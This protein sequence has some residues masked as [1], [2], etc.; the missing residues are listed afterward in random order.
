MQLFASFAD[1]IFF[2]CQSLNGNSSVRDYRTS[3]FRCR[4][5]QKGRALQAFVPVNYSAVKSRPPHEVFF[6]R[7]EASGFLLQRIRTSYSPKR[8]DGN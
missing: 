2:F 1:R 6:V 3:A 4:C 5:V 7:K 8:V